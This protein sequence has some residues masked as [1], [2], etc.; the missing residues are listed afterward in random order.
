MNE[1][2]PGE[3]PK[4][5]VSFNDLIVLRSIIRGYLAYMRR[6]ALSVLE[7]QKQMA[8]ARLLEGLYARLV[9]I[10][11]GAVEV[12]LPLTVPEVHAL[13][14]AML[15]FA[16]FVRQKVPPTRERDETLQ[17]LEGLR[18]ALIKTFSLS[19]AWPESAS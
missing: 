14:V 12:C 8:Q 1:Y 11:V 9:G 10:P 16:A 6:S 18:Q 17:T 7:R 2:D 5:L 15:G 3:M 4:L 13:N 19:T